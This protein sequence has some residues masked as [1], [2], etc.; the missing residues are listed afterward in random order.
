M[1]E[2]LQMSEKYEFK[3]DVGQAVIGNVQ[4]AQRLSNNNYVN[5]N[6]NSPKAEEPKVTSRQR[7]QIFGKVKEL[8]AARQLPDSNDHRLT[9]YG[10]ILDQF[11]I[12]RIDDLP[13]KHYKGVIA[14][15][16][17]WIT[18]AL[19][20]REIS[21]PDTATTTSPALTV[22]RDPALVST[23]S[24]ASDSQVAVEESPSFLRLQRIVR[25]QSVVL[26]ICIAVCGWVLYKMGLPFMEKSSAVLPEN[27]CYIAGRAYSIGHIE[28]SKGNLGMQCVGPAG[29]MPAMWLDANRGR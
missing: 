4:E 7:A 13:D 15:M 23:I 19:D 9:I 5:V 26:V 6:L 28:R 16:S 1:K 29:D 3:H 22:R 2:K 21:P 25:A 20:Q 18:E 12:N 24:V 11:H 14:M 27:R 17:R 10:T 8:M